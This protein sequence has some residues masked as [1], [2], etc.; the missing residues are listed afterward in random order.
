MISYIWN[1]ALIGPYKQ[2]STALLFTLLYY[3]WG[4][5]IRKFHIYDEH[6]LIE[7]VW[8]NDSYRISSRRSLV[9]RSRLSRRIERRRNRAPSRWEMGSGSLGRLVNAMQ[10][11]R[12][13]GPF[14]F[15]SV[16][17]ISFSS[18]S[19]CLSILP[20]G[21][22]S[23]FSRDSLQFLSTFFSLSVLKWSS[24]LK[25]FCFLLDLVCRLSR[26]ALKFLVVS[27]NDLVSGNCLVN[28][29]LRKFKP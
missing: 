16:F 4:T 18:S 9:V 10:H 20:L 6:E 29:K 1:S 14:P 28:S 27:V 5:F 25:E 22:F 26:S 2:S 3:V 19:S 21:H 8:N 17:S 23:P 24:I 7:V 11:G 12:H 15:S 13:N